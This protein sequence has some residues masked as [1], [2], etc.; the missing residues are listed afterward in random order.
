MSWINAPDGTI[1]YGKR[2]TLGIRIWLSPEG[3]NVDGEMFY[4]IWME[5]RLSRRIPFKMNEEIAILSENPA[6]MK[7]ELFAFDPIAV[8]RC[9]GVMTSFQQCPRCNKLQK[10]KVL[11]AMIDDEKDRLECTFC[12]F[13]F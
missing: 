7:A 10:V 8:A 11:L 6:K 13:Q 12:G 4:S 2:K 1:I 9:H 3:E 5:G